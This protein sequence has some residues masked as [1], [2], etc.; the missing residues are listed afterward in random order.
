MIYEIYTNGNEQMIVCKTDNAVKWIP[1][2]KENP[3]YQQYLTWVE[4]GNVAE[5]WNPDIIDVG[6]E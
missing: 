6:G 2:S 3:D 4:E 5:E 1:C